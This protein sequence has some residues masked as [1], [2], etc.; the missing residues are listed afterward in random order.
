MLNKQCYMLGWLKMSF[1]HAA[2]FR[3]S[4]VDASDGGVRSPIIATP[5]KPPPIHYSYTF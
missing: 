3:L 2:C 4:K 5:G 1:C